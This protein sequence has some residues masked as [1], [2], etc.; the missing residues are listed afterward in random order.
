MREAGGSCNEGSVETLDACCLL[1]DLGKRKKPK[2]V[3]CISAFK[4]VGIDGWCCVMALQHGRTAG[5]LW[6]DKAVL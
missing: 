5:L 4:D 2:C 1:A 6:A 3:C